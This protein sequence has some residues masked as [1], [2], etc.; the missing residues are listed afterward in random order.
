MISSKIIIN[1]ISASIIRNQE[2]LWQQETVS[3]KC[4]DFYDT[5]MWSKNLQLMNDK[6]PEWL[7]I[8]ILWYFCMQFKIYSFGVQCS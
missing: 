3:Y 2:N 5:E 8:I 7:Q 6:L 1:S 4:A